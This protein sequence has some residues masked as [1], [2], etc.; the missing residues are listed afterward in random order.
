MSSPRSTPSSASTSAGPMTRR[1]PAS[2]ARSARTMTVMSLARTRIVEVVRLLAE[3]RTTLPLHD[4]TG[5]VLGIDDLVPDLV[6]ARVRGL[7]HGTS[8]PVEG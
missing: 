7:V 4:G 2:S 1:M 6:V 3:H 5:T 8:Y